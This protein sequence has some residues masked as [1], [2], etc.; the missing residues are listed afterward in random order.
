MT[1][2]SSVDTVLT[3]TTSSALPDGEW[4]LNVRAV[5]SFGNWAPTAFHMGPFWIDTVGPSEPIL[6]SPPT[7][8]LNDNTPTI[9]WGIPSDLSGV[10]GYSY[11]VDAPP[12]D[13]IDTTS[14]SVNLPQLTDGQHV[15]YVKATDSVGN[16]GT[17]TSVILTVD[18]NP[19]SPEGPFGPWLIVL[20]VA[21]V[22]GVILTVIVIAVELSGKPK[23]G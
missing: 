20:I 21:V 7:G 12:D 11:S 2:D 8:V 4:Y 16:W 10:A 19:L 23:K 15:F 3:S 1:P 22:I 17:P 5:D 6:V 14:T 13:T 9:S 18:T